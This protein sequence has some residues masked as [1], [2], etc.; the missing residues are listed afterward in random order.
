[1]VVQH[2]Y[3][4]HG[5]LTSIKNTTTGTAYWTANS[6]DAKGNLK[7]QTLG[8][9]VIS[10]R[11]YDTLGRLESIVS[12]KG[13]TVL[14]DLGYKF[15][16][17][18]NLNMRENHINHVKEDFDYDNIYRLTSIATSATNTASLSN[19]GGALYGFAM[20][21]SLVTTG[22]VKP[23]VANKSFNYDGHGNIMAKQGKIYKY[24]GGRTHAVSRVDNKVFAYDANGNMRFSY[25]AGYSRSVHWKS[26]NKPK[27]IT[28]MDNNKGTYVKLAYDDA[29]S[30]ILKQSTFSDNNTNKIAKNTW[31]IAGGLVE[32]EETASGA[33]KGAEVYK[34][35]LKA[36]GQTVGYIQQFKSK[37]GRW[38]TEK[39]RYLLTDHLGS[40]DVITNEVGGV[41]MRTNFD[42]WGKRRNSSWTD[43]TTTELDAINAS[44]AEEAYKIGFTGHEHDDEVG[45]INMKGRMYDAEIGR[46][47]SADPFVQA[48]TDTQ[49]Y[50]RY[51][52]VRNNP[53]SLVD[54]SGYSWLSKL[55]KK[56][57]R[58]VK[59]WGRTILAIAAAY[60]TA[61]WASSF[62]LKGSLYGAMAG[63]AAAGFAGTLVST[64]SLKQALIGAAFGALSAGLANQIGYGTAFHKLGR[65]GKS[66][67]HGIAQGTVSVLRGNKFASGFVSAFASHITGGL[68]KFKTVAGRTAAAAVLGGTV[69]KLVGGKFANGAVTAAFTH[70]F[71]EEGGHFKDP[72]EMTLQ[73]LKDENKRLSKLLGLGL[74]ETGDGNFK[75]WDLDEAGNLIVVHSFNDGNI[76]VESLSWALVSSGYSLVKGVQ[77]MVTNPRVAFSVLATLGVRPSTMLSVP[78][79]AH[80]RNVAIHQTVKKD[81]ERAAAATA[82]IA[83]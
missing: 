7:K 30:R 67:A 51:S 68:N 14:Q 38:T 72:S 4:A 82:V 35:S 36:G 31:Y 53:L 78:T 43:A 6:A 77:M 32:R 83:Q 65:F 64:G 5:N 34:F 17:V 63:G 25:K 2:V 15:D 80:V 57:K 23:Y 3:N 73:D 21:M 50:S 19:T 54:P 48:A 29:H 1:V 24:L 55:W 42:A 70:L 76:P 22:G 58:F 45:L 27:S 33:N 12:N 71:N 75:I 16:V 62:F 81:I 26:F 11:T 52:Y 8:N 41:V 10:N 49:S 44:F 74:K 46:F 40:A 66:V 13:S 59:K 37:E 56:V 47:I 79:M 69:S 39:T 60:F 61:G 20:P 9:G 28:K 18:G